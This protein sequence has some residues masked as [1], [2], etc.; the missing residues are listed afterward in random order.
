ML[1]IMAFA[2]VLMG[3]GKSS[4]YQKGQQQTA[5]PIETQSFTGIIT[6]IDKKLRQISVREIDTDVDT[7]MN[8]DASSEITDKYKEEIDGNHIQNG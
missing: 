5:E 1:I 3:C 8:Y 6:R 7:I 2:G 4:N